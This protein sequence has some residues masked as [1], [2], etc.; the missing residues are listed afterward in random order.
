MSQQEG[1]RCSVR[2]FVVVATG[3]ACIGAVQYAVLEL[4][5]ELAPLT[6]HAIVAAQVSVALTVFSYLTYKYCGQ[7]KRV[8]VRR[9]GHDGEVSRSFVVRKRSK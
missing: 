6:K 7:P 4:L 3:I 8:P 5:L 9:I 2:E 1:E